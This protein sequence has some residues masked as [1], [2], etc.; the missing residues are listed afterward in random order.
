MDGNPVPNTST[1]TI[2]MESVVKL[3][4]DLDWYKT[5]G[6]DNIPARL[7]K[8]TAS[9]VAPILTIIFQASS[10][11]GKLPHDWKFPNIIPIFKKGNKRLA[12]NYR[13]ISLTSICCKT[14]EYIL[15]SFVS[16]HL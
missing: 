8:L 16:S 15:H 1:L 5:T 9:Q 10:N 7:L 6:P 4:Q 3:P 2:Q 11:Q 14:L 12:S 13:P